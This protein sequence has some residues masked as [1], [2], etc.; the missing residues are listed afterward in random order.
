MKKVL[1]LRKVF[2]H[3]VTEAPHVILEIAM[4]F[5]ITGTS[6]VMDYQGKTDEEVGILCG[7][8]YSEATDDSMDYAFVD[9]NDFVPLTNEEAD[10]LVFKL[11]E[12]EVNK[13]QQEKRDNFIR[14]ELG[15]N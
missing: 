11:M 13:I 3:M 6:V 8:G 10:S 9:E 12:D 4:E 7:N 1:D 2:A 14:T 15:M 5:M